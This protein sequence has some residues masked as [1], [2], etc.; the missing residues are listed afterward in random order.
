MDRLDANKA[1]GPWTRQILEWI[2][3]NP[4]VVSTVL[5]ALLER[6]LQPMKVDIRKLKALG[7]TI[8]SMSGIGSRPAA[9]PTWT[10]ST[11]DA[12]RSGRPD[13]SGCIQRG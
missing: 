2:R 7:L 5:A 8:S 1:S 9:R 11:A 13:Q 3:D 4:A 10:G 6:E 12:A